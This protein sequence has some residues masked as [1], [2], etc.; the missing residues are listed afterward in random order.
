MYLSGERL[1]SFSGVFGWITAP[2]STLVGL[3]IPLIML[4]NGFNSNRE[5]LLLASARFKILA[6]PF[7]FDV[8][9]HLLIAIPYLFWDYNKKEHE[10]VI[11]VLK[12]R[13]ALANEGFFPNTYEGGLDF[14][15]PE[16]LKSSIPANL[17][18]RAA[19]EPAQAETQTV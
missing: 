4:Q 11:D 14:E 17:P 1:Q 5:A 2:I 16:R 18:D 8:V 7:I 19:P 6:I 12:Q 9:G 10:Y 15:Q 3:I 13:E